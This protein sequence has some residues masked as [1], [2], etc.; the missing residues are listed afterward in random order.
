MGASKRTELGVLDRIF[1]QRIDCSD[2]EFEQLFLL[3]GNLFLMILF[4][5][6]EIGPEKSVALS[7]KLPEENI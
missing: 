1:D 4:Q 6:R 3:L 7:L 2:D 5:P